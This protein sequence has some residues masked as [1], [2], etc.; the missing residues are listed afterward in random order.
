MAAFLD[1]NDNCITLNSLFD[2]IDQSFVNDAVVNTT[3]RDSL[4]VALVTAQSM[5]YVAA[6]DGVYRTVILSSVDLGDDGDIVSVEV[7]AV[8]GDGSV[9]QA[10]DEAVYIKGRQLSGTA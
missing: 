5:P 7:N 1:L 3:I 9:Y 6:S 8:A 10:I 2:K 4:G